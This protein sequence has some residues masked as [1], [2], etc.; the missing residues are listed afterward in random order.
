MYNKIEYKNEI[1]FENLILNILIEILRYNYNE[2][3]YLL[4]VNS[5]I[6]Q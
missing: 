1:L 3:L 4:N 6:E 5:F 2:F